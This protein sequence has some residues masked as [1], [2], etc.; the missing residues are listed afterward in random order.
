MATTVTEV[1][2]P[3]GRAIRRWTRR[4]GRARS[5]APLSEFFGD[6]YTGVF[7]VVMATS[8]VISLS[9]DVARQGGTGPATLPGPGP[10]LQAEWLV[11][12]P[13][14]AAVAAF[15][16][17]VVRLGP[18]ALSGPEG[19]WWLPLAVERR[20]LLRPMA[21]RWPAVGAVLGGV[22]GA[23]VAV[24]TGSPAIVIVGSAL[25]GAA[26]TVGLVIAAGMT[27]RAPATHRAIRVS[28][29]LTLAAVPVTG[30]AVALAGV[31][32]PAPGPGLV[33]PAV[34]AAAVA[35]ALAARWERG[36]DA[37]PGAHLRARGVVADEA[38][39]A[40]LSLDPR[41]LGR[42]LAV[43]EER[44]GRARSSSMSWLARV[45]RRARPAAAL[46]TA[47]ALLLMRTPRHIAQV[48]LSATLPGLAL[49]AAK[50]S[51]VAVSA[52]VLI[53]AY[54]AAL[55]A[56][57]GARQAHMSPVLDSALPLS[58]SAVRLLRLVAPTV[59]MTGWMSAVTVMVGWRHGDLAGWVLLG[60]ASAPVW[61]AAVVR[62][63]YR[64]LPDFT[65]PQIDTPLGPLP[66]GGSAAM[67]QGPDV[68]LVGASP[69]VVALLI[70]AV[71]PFVLVLQAVL[72]AAA[73]ALTARP[74]RTVPPGRR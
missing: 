59:V 26:F 40:V 38:L 17:V 52:T 45:P 20:T 7:A 61:A 29:D 60:L 65:G 55:A 47:D 32:A 5:G 34:V 54:V 2:L 41:G 56:A 36:L 72:A 13:A 49:L 19:V 33:T 69:W 74:R 37:V 35:V 8:I 23:A 28:A 57:D 66:P 16:G 67:M 9:S 22:A 53:G 51:T 27:Q 62:A 11:M 3:S 70:G 1:G 24:A 46:V 18:L 44:S 15:T 43:R 48:I 31:P 39:V 50:P 64:P 14:L 42:A 71:P 21:A 73:I 12:L 25:L 6:V 10:G 68:A 4:R 58:H 63:A 30:L